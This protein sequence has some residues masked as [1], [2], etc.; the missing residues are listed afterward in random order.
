M[1]VA[2]TLEIILSIIQIIVFAVVSY[3]SARL[4]LKEEGRLFRVFF[5][6]GIMSLAL[7]YVYWIAYDLLRP[8]KRMPF[9]GNEIAD[10]AAV[11]LFASALALTLGRNRK[12][13]WESIIITFILMLP[14]IALWIVWSGQY[15]ENIIFGIPYMYFLYVI[16]LCIRQHGIF[17]RGEG[18]IIASVCAIIIILNYASLI[19]KDTARFTDPANYV[20]ENLL[21]L[22]L[23][24]RCIKSLK[25]EASGQKT[26]IL[27]FILFFYTCNVMFMSGGLIYE[28]ALLMNI[29]TIP[30]MYLS[31]KK[32][33]SE[34][35]C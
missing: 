33:Y 7:E 23:L 10:C 25:S 17:G 27:S 26:L 12:I 13:S 9:A 11:L 14:I 29:L 31:V 21:T 30:L 6:F 15:I 5:I 18:I 22:Y 8:G 20:I 24:I 35:A 2:I 1:S 16:L 4:K 32:E 34:D 19:A 28:L 3:T